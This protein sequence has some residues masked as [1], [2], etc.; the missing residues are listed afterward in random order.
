MLAA[1]MVTAS[2]LAGTTVPSSASGA[3]PWPVTSSPGV[4]R[5]G[6]PTWVEVYWLSWA[7]V[8][9]VKITAS[10]P[11]VEVGYPSNTGTYTSFSRSSSLAAGAGDYTAVRVRVP[12]RHGPVVA[13]RLRMTY[14]S[15]PAGM[16]WLGIRPADC[17]G[18]TYR[19]AYS[20][21]LLVT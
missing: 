13:L 16:F 6:E 18:R 3:A 12:Q 7:D 21:T 10:A 9:D 20:V 4:V 19:Q 17:H 2:L 14:V 1:L 5:A 8:C 15:V 11:G